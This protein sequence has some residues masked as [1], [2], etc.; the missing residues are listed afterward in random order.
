M[1]FTSKYTLPVTLIHTLAYKLIATHCSIRQFWQNN[2]MSFWIAAVQKLRQD[3]KKKYCCLSERNDILS[4]EKNHL[5]YRKKAQKLQVT[6]KWCKFFTNM[7]KMWLNYLTY[8]LRWDSF[9][10]GLKGRLILKAKFI[11]FIWTKNQTKIFLYFCPS[12]LKWV[13]WKNI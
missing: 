10:L 7:L 5:H 9:L 4:P 8:W 2:F 13:K 1:F 3:R 12:S 6:K 11:V